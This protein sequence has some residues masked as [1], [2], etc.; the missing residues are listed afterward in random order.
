MCS[1]A[2]TPCWQQL[3]LPAF[4]YLLL[5]QLSPKTVCWLQGSIQGALSAVPLELALRYG[6]QH[7]GQ[8]SLTIVTTAVLG[9]VLAATISW[10]AVLLMGPRVLPRVRL[11]AI[12]LPF[13]A[14]GLLEDALAQHGC[15]LL[16][17]AR[18]AQLQNGQLQA[19]DERAADLPQWT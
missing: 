8:Q 6:Q 15:I 18:M 7:R 10:F 9:I 12:V 19:A 2:M 14:D 13:C 16:L 17:E 11:Q 4:Q 5:V 3:F 1:A